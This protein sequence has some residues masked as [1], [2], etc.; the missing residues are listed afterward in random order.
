[1]E[2]APMPAACKLLAPRFSVVKVMVD[3]VLADIR[4]VWDSKS[5]R[6]SETL[7]APIFMLDDWGDMKEHVVK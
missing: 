2:R 6:H 5:N 3:G 7:W 4:L 1:M